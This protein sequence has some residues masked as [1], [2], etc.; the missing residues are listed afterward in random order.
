MRRRVREAFSGVDV[1]GYG[2]ASNADVEAGRRGESTG[3]AG[4]DLVGIAA[5]GGAAAGGLDPEA[6]VEGPEWLGGGAAEL[7]QMGAGVGDDL[8]V[9]IGGHGGGRW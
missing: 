8:T 6:V 9:D 5:D 3:G 2:G 4:G 7:G 1:A